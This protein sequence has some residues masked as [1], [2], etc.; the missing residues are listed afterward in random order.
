MK[1]YHTVCDSQQNERVRT[2]KIL[3]RLKTH[4]K[5]ELLNWQKGGKMFC[6]ERKKKSR[7]F[8]KVSDVGRAASSEKFV[9]EKVA[10]AKTN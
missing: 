9:N 8:F 5:E 3:N 4:L 2:F 1:S 6:G 10:N 7:N